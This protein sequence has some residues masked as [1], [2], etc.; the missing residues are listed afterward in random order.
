MIT[1]FS[2]GHW[3]HQ[4][5]GELLYSAFVPAFEKPER[6]EL[7]RARVEEVG[8][9][10]IREPEVFPLAAITGIHAPG[11]VDLLMNAHAEWV[12]MGREGAA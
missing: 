3:L 12:A 8:L 7:I 9:G 11:L 2:P 1:I 5:P 4:S 10:P 6:A